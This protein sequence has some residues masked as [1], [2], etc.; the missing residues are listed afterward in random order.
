MTDADLLREFHREANRILIDAEYT[1][2]QHMLYARRWRRHSVWMG[3][4]TVVVAAVTSAAA[5]LSA[6]LGGEAVVT[7]AL[8]LLSAL[9]S[10]VRLFFQPDEQAARHGTK[11]EEYVTVRNEARRFMNI[12]LRSPLSSDTLTDRLRTLGSRY[13]AL[14]SRGPTGL[15]EWTYVQARAEIAAGNY[16]YEADQLWSDYDPTGQRAEP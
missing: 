12:D 5:A 2:R 10:A 14:R 1:G 9:S 11:G 13:D 15:S 16:D 8:A 4:P 3:L 7:A 6:L